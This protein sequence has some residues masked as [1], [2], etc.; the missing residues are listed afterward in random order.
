MFS[1]AKNGLALLAATALCEIGCRLL[2]SIMR[3]RF[4]EAPRPQVMQLTRSRAGL[5]IQLYL[6][7]DVNTEVGKVG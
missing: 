7:S 2:F 3:Q 5:V 4:R 6:T 1:R